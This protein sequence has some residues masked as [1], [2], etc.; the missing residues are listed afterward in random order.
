MKYSHT[1]LA[2]AGA[3]AALSHVPVMAEEKLP[4]AEVYYGD[5]NL[6]SEHGVNQ[7][8]RRID[9]AITIVCGDDMPFDIL[10]TPGIRACQR[11]TLTAVMPARDEVIDRA[12]RGQGKVEVLALT[13]TRPSSRQ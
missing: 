10:F 7:L 5:L 4:T 13:V 9:R 11:E 12:L 8:D 1:I 2:V 6:L 3:F